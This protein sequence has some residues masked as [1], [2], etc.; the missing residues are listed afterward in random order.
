MKNLVL[1]FALMLLGPLLTGCSE[2][3]V[4][5]P[6]LQARVVDVADPCSGEIVLELTKEDQNSGNG[7]CGTANIYKYV[8][9]NNLPDNLKQIGA[10]FTCQIETRESER[11]CIAI[12]P[13]YEAATIKNICNSNQVLPR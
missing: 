11:G 10:T 1:I 9:V 3:D 2:E 5:V 6:C 13:M 8:V 7:F 4:A 12:Y